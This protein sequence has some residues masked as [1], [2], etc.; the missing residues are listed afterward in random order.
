MGFAGTV[1]MLHAAGAGP[2]SLA[3][4]ADHLGATGAR[5]RMPA[6]P[7]AIDAEASSAGQPLAAQ[8]AAARGALARA[9]DASLLVGHSLGGS[10]ALLTMLEGAGVAGAVLYEPI[11]LAA[12]EPADPGDAAGR[13]WDRALVEGLAAGVENGDPEP[14][15]ARFVEAWNEVAWGELVPAVRDRALGDAGALAALAAAV[16]HHPL[17]RVALQRLDVPVLLLAGDRSPDVARRMARRL[18]GLLPQAELRTVAAAG[19]MG[20]VRAPGVVASVIR[21]WLRRVAR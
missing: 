11:V 3:P 8:V 17:D 20:P 9:G 16:H 4:L 10:V 7:L 2:R 14:G 12:L 15:V 18:A 1:V 5:L 13:A 19:H 6:L 21:D